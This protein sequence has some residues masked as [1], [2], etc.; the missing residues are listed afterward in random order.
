MD[1]CD[2]KCRIYE[3]LKLLMKERRKISKQYYELK[4]YLISLENGKISENDLETVPQVL[5]KKRVDLHSEKELQDYFTQRK[6]PD[7]YHRSYKDYGFII[8]SILKESGKPL[9]NRQ[10]YEALSK[11]LILFLTIEIL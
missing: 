10:L 9:S 11:K 2:E 6:V 7:N 1:I 3:Q 5:E 4:E 8:A